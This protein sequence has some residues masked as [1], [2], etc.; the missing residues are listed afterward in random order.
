MW[1]KLGE[2]FLNLHHVVRISFSTGWKNDR[3]E[4]VAQVEGYVR[5]NIEGLARYRGAEAQ[6]LRAY[7]GEMS[8]EPKATSSLQASVV[9]PKVEMNSKETMPEIDLQQL[10]SGGGNTIHDL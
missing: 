10:S 8:Y 4:L 5:G 3:E 1:L 7:I 2:E 9:A 6:A